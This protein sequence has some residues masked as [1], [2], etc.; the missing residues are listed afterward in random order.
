M[1]VEPRGDRWRVRYREGDS[2]R[3][4]TFANEGDA[5]EFDKKAKRLRAGGTPVPRRKDMPTLQEFAEDWFAEQTHWEDSTQVAYDNLLRTHIYPSIG[6]LHVI[7]ADLRI[8]RLDE[9]R[10]ERLRKG[11]AKTL[12]PAIGV[13]NR[14]LN[15]AV[16][17]EYISGN[18]VPALESVKT[19]PR[20]DA[21][22]LLPI[23]VERLR[24]WFIERDDWWSATLISVLAY[25]GIRQGEAFALDWPDF[26]EK[27]YVAKRVM[28]GVVIPGTKKD[29]NDKSYRTVPEPVAQ[30]LREWR[31]KSGNRSGLIFPGPEGDPMTKSNIGNW[32]GHKNRK[33]SCFWQAKKD[34]GIDMKFRVHDLRDTAASLLAA[35][36]ETAD[37]VANQL[38]HS[39][40]VSLSHY[41]H[42]IEGLEAKGKTLD[43]LILE[44]RGETGEDEA[45]AAAI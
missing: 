21:N 6:H 13:L 5:R 29:R 9:W 34:C 4:A 36:G 22:P 19:T 43:G 30:D 39:V 27:L 40:G 7:D 41:R 14:I 42:F 15:A 25:V 20:C 31:F 12:R 33:G 38:G 1:S 11:S 37:A 17:A 35:T 2:H 28:D 23:E 45:A 8:G 16:V 3:S 26:G 24:A 10:K 44:A 32:R 18:P